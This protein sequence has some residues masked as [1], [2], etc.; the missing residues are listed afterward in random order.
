MIN[1]RLRA[2][3]RNKWGFM[4]LLILEMRPIVEEHVYID[5]LNAPVTSRVISFYQEEN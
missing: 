1:Q 4:Q 2:L 5:L 3:K